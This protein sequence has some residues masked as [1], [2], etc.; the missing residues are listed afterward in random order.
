[1]HGFP[2]SRARSSV[3]TLEYTTPIKKKKRKKRTQNPPE[4]WRRP[5]LMPERKQFARKERGGTHTVTF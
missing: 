2:F 3:H 1:M 4:P 5:S